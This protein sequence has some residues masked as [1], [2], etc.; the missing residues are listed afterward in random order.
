MHPGERVFDSFASRT[1]PRLL[2]PV[3]FVIAH[4]DRFDPDRGTCPGVG[5]GRRVSSALTYR[6]RVD[7][8]RPVGFPQEAAS[9]PVATAPDFLN[10]NIVN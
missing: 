4:D 2:R 1:R 7:P 8:I 6:H 3:A 9:R 5:P 10:F